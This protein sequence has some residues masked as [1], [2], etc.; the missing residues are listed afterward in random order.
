VI[1]QKCLPGLRGGPTR[2]WHVLS[3]GGLTN[4]NAE[5]DQFAMDA[6]STPAWIGQAHRSYQLP[7]LARFAWSA[8]TGTALPGPIQPES[9]TIPG[10]DCLW[11]QDPHRRAPALPQARQPD[12]EDAIRSPQPKPMALSGTLQDQKLVPQRQDLSL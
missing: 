10:D 9:L 3:H 5:L 1:L 11:L 2:T 8:F 12:P 6:R 4:V 7:N